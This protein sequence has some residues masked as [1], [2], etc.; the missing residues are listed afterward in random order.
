M[1]R[2]LMP[3]K[4]MGEDRTIRLVQPGELV[5][6]VAG[7]KDVKE[8]MRRGWITDADG[9]TP[10]EKKAPPPPPP[11]EDPT[12][13]LKAKLKSQIVHIAEAM[14]LDTSGTKAEIIEAILSASQE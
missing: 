1:Y 14:N 6:E 13:E 7:W 4:V 10:G 9:N 5:P 8:Y 11:P 2:A 12:Y 3:F